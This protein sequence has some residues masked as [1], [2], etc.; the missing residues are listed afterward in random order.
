M[1]VCQLS[2]SP[3]RS[4]AAIII[5]PFHWDWLK[6]LNVGEKHSHT[7]ELVR[8][9]THHH[10]HCHSHIIN[11]VYVNDVKKLLS[12]VYGSNKMTLHTR[13]PKSITKI[14]IYFYVQVDV[15]ACVLISRAHSLPRSLSLSLPLARS[16]LFRMPLCGK[17]IAIGP[18][19]K[20]IPK[21]GAMRFRP[22][23][24]I[25][26]GVEPYCCECAVRRIFTICRKVCRT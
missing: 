26:G 21:L 14:K 19:N 12:H 13:A 4:L 22:N 24:P 15:D 18:K 1:Y 3:N 23:K 8:A 9:Q 11:D 10:T 7:Y 20:I 2:P 6:W 25:S 17:S 5:Y 16:L